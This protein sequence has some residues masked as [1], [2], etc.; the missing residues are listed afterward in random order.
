[1]QQ[2]V[3]ENDRKVRLYIILQEMLEV[4]YKEEDSLRPPNLSFSLNLIYNAKSKYKK[5]EI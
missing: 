5:C 2:R 3:K 4:N 1:M